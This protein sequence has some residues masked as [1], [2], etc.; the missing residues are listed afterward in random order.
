M[1]VHIPVICTDFAIVTDA[2]TLLY[3][4][5]APIIH[6]LSQIS[7]NPMFNADDLFGHSQRLP[8]YI[9]FLLIFLTLLL[10]RVLSRGHQFRHIPGNRRRSTSA[11]RRRRSSFAAASPV[12]RRRR[13]RG[14]R[15]SESRG[16]RPRSRMHRQVLSG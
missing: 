8:I 14:R 1:Y 4:T 6:A 12:A 5:M 2:Q 7:V 11:P 16:C 10:L 9:R 3:S 13:N 15:R